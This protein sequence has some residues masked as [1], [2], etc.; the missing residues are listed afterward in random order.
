MPKFDITPQVSREYKIYQVTG[1]QAIQMPYSR[2]SDWQQTLQVYAKM[3][4]MT[5]YSTSIGASLSQSSVRRQK[6]AE[7]FAQL[8]QM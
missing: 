2:D 7:I 1:K 6:P 4:N 8:E 5:S 3:L